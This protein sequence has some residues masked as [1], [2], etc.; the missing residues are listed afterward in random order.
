MKS[1]PH[2]VINLVLDGMALATLGLLILWAANLAVNLWIR[3]RH[4]LRSRRTSRHKPHEKEDG[5][6]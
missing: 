1:S 5:L 6:S 4:E 3:I 2:P